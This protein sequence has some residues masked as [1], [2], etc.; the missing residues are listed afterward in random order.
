MK[1]VIIFAHP[2]VESGSIANRIIFNEIEGVRDV[3]IRN[4]HQMYPDFKIDAEAEQKS[5]LE[6]DVIIFQFPFHWYSIPGILKEWLDKVFLYGFAYGGAGD[7]LN[8]KEFLISTTVGGP[9]VS[10]QEGRHNS[11]TVEE[12]LRPL[13]Q[14]A[15]LAGMNFNQ[16]L[17]THNMV[18]IPDVYNKKEEVEQRARAHAGRLLRFINETASNKLKLLEMLKV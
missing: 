5:L 7:M 3:E 13:E 1:T 12:F 18:Y 15:K 6:S 11:F 9:A 14:T 8:G 4:I 16:P 17:V 2:N 10:Y